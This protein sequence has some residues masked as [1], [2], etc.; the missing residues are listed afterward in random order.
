[1]VHRPVRECVDAGGLIAQLH[2][3]AGTVQRLLQIRKGLQIAAGNQGAGPAMAFMGMNMAGAA[4]GMNAQN[5]YQMGAQ[6]PAAQPAPAPAPAGWTCSC[7]QTGNTGKFCANCG[8]P[9]PAP[10]PAA[11]S[12]VCSCGTSNTGKFCCNC[13][14]PK[15]APA[16]AKCSQCGWTPVDPAHPPKFCPECGKPFG[17]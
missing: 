6:Q 10:A 14:N 12:W 8:S 7:G 1:M 9:K 4:G 3:A 17:Q 16:P 13:G 15:P 2:T 11:G 5:L